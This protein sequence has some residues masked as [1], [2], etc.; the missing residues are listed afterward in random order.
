[1]WLPTNN[2]PVPNT[3]HKYWSNVADILHSAN[4]QPVPVSQRTSP[5][6]LDWQPPITNRSEQRQLKGQ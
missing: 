2:P 6:P 5:P 1:M 4:Y 3:A